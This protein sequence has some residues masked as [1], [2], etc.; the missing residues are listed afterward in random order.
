M[1]LELPTTR[2]NEAC[3]ELVRETTPELWEAFRDRLKPAAEGAGEPEDR[4]RAVRRL[5]DEI[6]A[7]FLEH[8]RDRRA[9]ALGRSWAC[10]V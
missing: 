4:V 9:R 1:A 3:Y 8:D 10:C 6:W 2:A 7:A 5:A